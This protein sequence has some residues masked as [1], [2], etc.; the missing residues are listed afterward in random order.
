MRCAATAIRCTANAPP[1]SW[2]HGSSISAIAPP[3]RRPRVAR[4]PISCRSSAVRLTPPGH[5]GRVD[6]SA[7]RRS[8]IGKGGMRIYLDYNA[9]TPVREEVAA[10][11]IRVLRDVPG[12]PS[13]VHAEGAAARAEVDAARERVAALLG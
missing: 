2:S 8:K 12:N 4:S 1:A 3:A 7:G 9:T 5:A 10:Q 11:M 6:T 13:S